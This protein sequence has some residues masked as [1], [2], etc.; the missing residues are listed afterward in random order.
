MKKFKHKK[1]ALIACMLI[2]VFLSSSPCFALKLRV[3]NRVREGRDLSSQND[4]FLA[5]FSKLTEGELPDGYTIYA[6]SASAVT[7]EKTEVLNGKKSNVLILSDNTGGT[8]TGNTYIK[9]SFSPVSKGEIAMEFRFKI[10]GED[11]FAAGMY[12]TSGGSWAT[13][14]TVRN[15]TGNFDFM[16]S[17]TYS[18]GTFKKGVWN[19]VRVVVNLDT[20]LARVMCTIH[21]EKESTIYRDNQSLW[22]SVSYIDGITFETRNLTG[23]MFI[24]YFKVETGTALEIKVPDFKRPEPEEA[25]ISAA[26]VMR[27]VPKRI[28]IFVDEEVMYFDAAPVERDGEIYSDRLHVLRA[29]GQ[30]PKAGESWSELVSVNRIAEELGYE[31]QYKPE[32]KKMY[33]KKGTAE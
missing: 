30:I 23:K 28:N 6:D 33:I 20:K 18:N 25:P 9:R 21:D 27:P 31:V 13:R 22:S 4:L 12:F 19:T 2:G 29:F 3:D 24:D 15:D 11:R 8:A 16:P 1:I 7:T 32:E 26:P 10:E 5:D 17:G 14:M